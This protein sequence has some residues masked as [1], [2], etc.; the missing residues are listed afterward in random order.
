MSISDGS[1]IEPNDP[2]NVPAEHCDSMERAELSFSIGEWVEV[3]HSA[4]ATYTP[5][6]I[7]G[8]CLA[9]G[10]GATI[11]ACMQVETP[12]WVIITVVT[13]QVIGL[14]ILALR[15]QGGGRA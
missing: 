15:R 11:W 1:F 7:S 10:P 13:I 12:E 6:M 9:F 3:G 8:T 5:T 4:P 14:V 2:Q